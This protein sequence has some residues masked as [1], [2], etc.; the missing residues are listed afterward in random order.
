MDLVRHADREANAQDA[1]GDSH[2]VEVAVP[3]EESAGR[4]APDK[5]GKDKK[6]IGNVGGSEKCGGGQDGC[7]FA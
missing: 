7:G 6:R 1:V 5:S 3:Q 4:E 2:G